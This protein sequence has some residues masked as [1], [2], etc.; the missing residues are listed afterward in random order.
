MSDEGLIRG[1]RPETLNEWLLINIVWTINRD[2]FFFSS[3]GII[4]VYLTSL[5][6]LH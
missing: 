1:H 6:Q 5:I 3:E 4:P 2:G